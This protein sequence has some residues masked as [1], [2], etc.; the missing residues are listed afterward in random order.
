MGGFLSTTYNCPVTDKYG[1]SWMK[2]DLSI[3]VDGSGNGSFSIKMT[4][5]W[6]GTGNCTG[7][8]VLYI[9]GT[10][11]HD[12]Y[13]NGSY[14]PSASANTNPSWTT[15]FPI[16]NNSSMSGTFSVGSASSFTVHYAV[17]R[18]QSAVTYSNS[19]RLT[20][21]TASV[22]GSYAFTFTRTTWSNIGTGSVTITDNGNNSYTVSGTKGGAGTNNAVNGA[23][24]YWAS[25]K[26]SAG[27][28]DYSYQSFTTGSS[29][30]VS[31][32]PTSAASRTVAGAVVTD[33]VY[34][35]TDT[36][37]ITK[38]I[39]QY[40]DPSAPGK[41]TL[42]SSSYRN[43][44]LTIK[45][46]WKYV[47]SEASN[48]TDSCPVLGY[49]IRIYRNGSLITGFSAGSNSVLVK[50]SG[51][52]EYVDRSGKADCAIIL[53][54]VSFGFVPGDTIQ[55]G[56]YS[57]AQNGAGTWLYNGGGVDV[58]QVLS[59]SSTVQ[60]S[61]VMRVRPSGSWKEGVVSIKVNNAWKEAEVVYTKVSGAWKES[62]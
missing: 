24:L 3:T 15:G 38:S 46:N 6:G 20:D 8:L 61:G 62:T 11:M 22:W 60:N 1:S 12:L 53:D 57:Y 26:N 19:N 47:W 55:I 34:N 59:D 45:Q 36:G 50:N 35:D 29:K 17:C 31:F 16:R 13:Y 14:T 58:A 27:N 44:R 4:N 39:K 30:T 41:P 42:D 23:T 9:N 10:K 28:W 40:R 48:G 49:R 2:G 52:N 7:S 18:S 56:I 5:D 54:P 25:G 33:G 32:T 43:G 37:W 21:G 51:T